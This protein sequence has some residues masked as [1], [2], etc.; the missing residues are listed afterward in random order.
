[1]SG[2]KTAAT[3]LIIDDEA[4]FRNLI[5]WRLERGD[6]FR[7]LMA[8]DGQT[9]IQ[10]AREHHPDVIL[11]DYSMPHMNGYEVLEA[12]HADLA[13]RHI[14]VIL[15]SALGSEQKATESISH[16]AVSHLEKWSD[17]KVLMEE[18]N[19]ALAKHRQTHP[20]E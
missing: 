13:T 17:A 5:S 12:L 10:M 7:V 9:G 15:L 16:G 4:D 14:P 20:S 11:T 3:V 8:E 1:M 19:R 6:V 2:A 18:I